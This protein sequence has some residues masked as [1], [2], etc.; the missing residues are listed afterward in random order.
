MAELVFGVCVPPNRRISS[1]RNTFKFSIMSRLIFLSWVLLFSGVLYGQYNGGGGDG[2]DRTHA[3][4][5]DLEGIPSGVRPLY[6]GGPG[7]GY[8][9]RTGFGTLA[10]S[11][12]GALFAGGRGDGYA[13]KSAIGVLSGTDLAQLYGGGTGDGFDHGQAAFTPDGQSLS[14][15]FAGGPGDGYADRRSAATLD[16]TALANLY[17]GGEGDGYAHHTAA[18][19]LGMAMT[20]LYG[21]GAGDG[22][23]RRAASLALDGTDLAGLFAGGGGDGA[24]RALYFGV[25]PLPLTLISF[26]AFPQEQYVLLRWVTEDEVGT[27]FFTVEK[28]R[29]G[30]DYAW[31]GETPA[32]GF[33]TSGEQ[34]HYDLTDPS[35]YRGR[36]Y[37]RLKTTD[38]DGSISLSHL[39]E[40]TYSAS[41]D[42][43]FE[44]FPNPN[45]GQHFNLSLDGLPA[46]ESLRLEVVDAAG[47]IVHREVFN[48]SLGAPLRFDLRS[49][50]APGSYLIR[51]THPT[52]GS[53]VKI[54]IVG[55]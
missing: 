46:G 29:D 6:A 20:M 15:L 32:A 38:F 27:D 30:R 37:Y 19:L 13:R 3:L 28:T 22:F 44:L 24:D 51:L 53:A 42:W 55:R 45:T 47:R 11:G 9:S 23:D 39:V 21:G 4:Q 43:Q 12:N 7:D 54:L 34:R 35:P 16:G 2:V 31:V 48:G 17:G 18:E 41:R 49:R 26:D 25:I 8:A 50:L 5:L 40:V 14:G 10:S 52:R 33:S 1:Y 36:S